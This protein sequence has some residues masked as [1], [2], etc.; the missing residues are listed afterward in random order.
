MMGQWKNWTNK[1]MR[2]FTY[3]PRIS[4]L[5]HFRFP[6]HLS[7]GKIRSII[8][9]RSG[10][11]QHSSPANKRQQK[12]IKWHRKGLRKSGRSSPEIRIRWKGSADFIRRTAG[13]RWCAGIRP[14]RMFCARSPEKLPGKPATKLRWPDFR[15]ELTPK[16]L[17]PS[18][19]MPI[20]FFA[21]GFK[22]F[23]Q[24]KI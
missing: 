19:R 6:F 11:R 13:C 1:R 12:E 3:F 21:L 16:S 22:V 8:S 7:R 23:L 17:I 5:H 14:G 4:I 15:F 9:I 10:D 2:I 20:D 24:P 18:D